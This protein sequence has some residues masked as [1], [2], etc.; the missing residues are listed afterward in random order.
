MHDS[1]L[2]PERNVGGGF[3]VEVKLDDENY[4]KVCDADVGTAVTIEGF[5]ERDFTGNESGVYIRRGY[6][7]L[8]TDGITLDEV[9][10]TQVHAKASAAGADGNLYPK[11]T[12]ITIQGTRT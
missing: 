4:Q 2:Y 10:V 9:V 1:T 8:F 12:K 5:A 7:Q 11:K 6:D 3:N